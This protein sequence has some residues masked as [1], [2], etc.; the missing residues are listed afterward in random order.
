MINLRVKQLISSVSLSTLY[1]IHLL[2][3]HPRTSSKKVLCALCVETDTKTEQMSKPIPKQD[4]A[5]T[6]TNQSKCAE[7][8]IINNFGSAIIYTGRDR[9]I[10]PHLGHIT[11]SV[12]LSPCPHW[13]T[14][15]SSSVNTW[16]QASQ[17]IV[18]PHLNKR[19]RFS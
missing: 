4:K 17:I 6:S 18:S 1:L 8:P 9:C 14:S 3:L 10:W 13:H 12:E 11:C 7:E 5:Q 19:E 2:I 16:P 15:T